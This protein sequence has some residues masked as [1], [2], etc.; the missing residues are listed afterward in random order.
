VTDHSTVFQALRAA[1]VVLRRFSL[2]QLT[3]GECKRFARE[4]H[5]QL[6]A[7]TVVYHGPKDGPGHWMIRYRRRHYD[8]EHSVGV[9]RWR[10]LMPWYPTRAELR[11]IIA[12]CR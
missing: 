10:D 6:P 9:T 8:A 11:R 5:R 12:R 2:W 7:A 3:H 4:V 1:R